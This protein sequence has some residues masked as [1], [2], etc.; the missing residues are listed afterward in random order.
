MKAKELAMVIYDITAKFPREEVYGLT[1]QMRRAS[2][3]IPSNIAEGV[4]RG[5]Y[6]GTI[7]FLFIARGSL[8]E[9]E[10]QLIIANEL[11]YL[12]N[13]AFQKTLEKIGECKRLLNGFIRY[14]ES[15][16]KT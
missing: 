2:V 10:T 16:T 15:K 13:E 6:R 4:G 11:T 12:A 9:L 5:T 14:Y 3:S 1:S 7:P 8:Y